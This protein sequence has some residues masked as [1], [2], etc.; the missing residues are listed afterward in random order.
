LLFTKY[1][2]KLLFTLSVLCR[3]LHENCRFFDVSEI[4]GTGGSLLLILFIYL[5]LYSKNQNQWFF[6]FENLKEP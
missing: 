2:K 4:A 3:F 5:F 6:D 1:Q